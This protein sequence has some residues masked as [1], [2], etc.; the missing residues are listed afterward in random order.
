VLSHEKKSIKRGFTYTNRG[1]YIPELNLYNLHLKSNCAYANLVSLEKF[2]FENDLTQS[3]SI[4]SLNYSFTSRLYTQMYGVVALANKYPHLTTQQIHNIIDIIYER[5]TPF[6][7]VLLDLLKIV[8]TNSYF[9]LG[10][11]IFR[12]TTFE[13]RDKYSSLF[14]QVE[15]NKFIQAVNIHWIKSF[16]RWICKELMS[17]AI[18][19]FKPADQVNPDIVIKE[20]CSTQINPNYKLVNSPNLLNLV[21]CG[22]INTILI[23]LDRIRIKKYSYK[24]KPIEDEPFN[25]FVKMQMNSWGNDVIFNLCD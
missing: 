22:D 1:I 15:W 2:Y 16:E 12:N 13:L 9:D 7:Q 3:E 5:K 18:Q 4:Y 8:P 24:S 21:I 17:Q 10:I 25:H 20:F 14:E 23:N 6:D 19:D 11:N